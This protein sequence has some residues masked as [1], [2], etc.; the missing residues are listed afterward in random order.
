LISNHDPKE[1][2]KQLYETMRYFLDDL[3]ERIDLTNPT[4]LSAL[5]QA[6]LDLL[7]TTA[8]RKAKLSQMGLPIY[9][10]NKDTIYRA[11]SAYNIVGFDPDG[12]PLVEPKP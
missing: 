2:N 7:A 4:D 8:K 12:M 9:L 1:G 5:P 11:G 3:S 6:D 10:Q